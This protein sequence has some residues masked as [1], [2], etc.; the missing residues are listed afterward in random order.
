MWATGL[1]A[2]LFKAA[3]VMLSGIRGGQTIATSVA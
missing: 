1:S 3:R 2:D